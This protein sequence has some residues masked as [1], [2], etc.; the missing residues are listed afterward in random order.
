MDG[1]LP[2]RPNPNSC[3]VNLRDTAS[4]GLV[5]EAVTGKRGPFRVGDRDQQAATRGCNSGT[6]DSE[7]QN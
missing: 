5:T 4:A 1:A 2:V 7:V 3:V 6:S